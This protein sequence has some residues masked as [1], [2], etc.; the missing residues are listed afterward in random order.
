VLV[1]AAI[2]LGAIAAP[3]M[4]APAVTY[5]LPNPWTAPAVPPEEGPGYALGGPPARGLDARG[6]ATAATV[7][8]G[9]SI[10]FGTSL[11][12][13]MAG[14][15]G[16][17]IGVGLGQ[18][19]LDAVVGL[20][21]YQMAAEAIRNRPLGGV[22]TSLLTIGAYVIVPVILANTIYSLV[23]AWDVYHLPAWSPP[24]GPVTP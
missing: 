19:G 20:V 14:E 23:A 1:A 15:T 17:G 11:G 18:V 22:D 13:V 6:Y 8:A 2:A 7:A 5:T 21:G 24:P 16:R 12:Y 3:A 10:P 4:A 9:V